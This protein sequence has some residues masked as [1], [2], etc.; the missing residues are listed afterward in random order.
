MQP[1]RLFLCTLFVSLATVTDGSAV[2]WTDA[3]AS[4]DSALSVLKDWTSGELKTYDYWK[5]AVKEQ[6]TYIYTPGKQ[7]VWMV[8]TNGLDADHTYEA[9][10]AAW[11][12]TKNGITATELR[13]NG[14]DM[15]LFKGLLN[16]D[17]VV[18][19]DTGNIR[20]V[21]AEIN[22]AKGQCVK[23]YL[24]GRGRSPSCTSAVRAY[25]EAIDS[26]AVGT[27]KKLDDVLRD[28]NL[29]RNLYPT[30]S[31]T[32]DRFMQSIGKRAMLQ[33]QGHISTVLL[34]LGSSHGSLV[35]TILW[36]NGL[37]M[38]KPSPASK[39]AQTYQNYRVPAG[40]DRL[41]RSILSYRRRSRQTFGDFGDQGSVLDAVP[42]VSP[43]IKWWTPQALP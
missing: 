20:F 40:P 37:Q 7:S 12:L 41:F 27:A 3:A 31:Y 21:D 25:C 22:R 19:R 30:N 14:D 35:C 28:L 23:A 32:W 8:E 39:E 10:M 17:K 42:S 13:S 9:Q 6:I 1:Y 24:E 11:V 33:E 26:I 5:W 36:H 15:A 29:G 38:G 18:Y 34:L 43:E 4:N 2:K 16:G